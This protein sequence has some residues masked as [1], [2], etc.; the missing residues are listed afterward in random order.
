MFCG[1][2]AGFDVGRFKIRV[3]NLG[4]SNLGAQTN[5]C[6]QMTCYFVFR[7]QKQYKV[8]LSSSKD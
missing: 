2:T 5:V 7:M 4:T 1:M 8:I 3:P 6:Q